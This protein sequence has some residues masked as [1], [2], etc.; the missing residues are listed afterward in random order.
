MRVNLSKTLRSIFLASALLFSG[1]SALAQE[2]DLQFDFSPA[3]SAATNKKCTPDKDKKNLYE[4]DFGELLK[5]KSGN[6]ERAWEIYEFYQLR[7]IK[8]DSTVTKVSV[9]RL[10]TEI[11]VL[12]SLDPTQPITLEIDSGGGSV[13]HG[14]RLYNAMKASKSPIHTHANGMAASMAAILLIAGDEREATPESRILIHQVSAGTMGKTDD[15][16]HDINHVNTLQD[17]LYE[18]IS[19]NT[20]LSMDDIRRIAGS[21]VFYDGEESVRL[22]FIDRLVDSKKGRDIEPGSRQ[23]PDSLYPENRVQEYYKRRANTPS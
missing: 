8:L 12:D 17:D 5:E 7:R 14:L 1:G 10:I 16:E 23:V 22:G 21:D 11:E 4:M 9:D 20:G 6:Y 13:Y 3:L 2:Y 15:M 19:E 18:I